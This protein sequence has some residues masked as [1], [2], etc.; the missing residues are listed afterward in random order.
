[1]KF[2]GIA[3]TMCTAEWSYKSSLGQAS[4]KSKFQMIFAKMHLFPVSK[5]RLAQTYTNEDNLV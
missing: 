1:M 4:S 5:Y 3:H 2:L